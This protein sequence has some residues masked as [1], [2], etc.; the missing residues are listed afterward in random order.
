[1]CAP[2]K[3]ARNTAGSLNQGGVR[4]VCRRF[5]VF[6]GPLPDQGISIDSARLDCLEKTTA[7]VKQAGNQKIQLQIT[8]T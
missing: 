1:M 6:V 5:L 7:R 3:K 4:P 8:F 2:E